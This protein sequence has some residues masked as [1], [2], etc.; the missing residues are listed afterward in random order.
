MS[1]FKSLCIGACATLVV[2]FFVFCVGTTFKACIG[3]RAK[4]KQELGKRL[5]VIDGGEW[6]DVRT[7]TVT[8]VRIHDSMEKNWNDVPFFSRIV[9]CNN[10]LSFQRQRYLHGGIFHT[11]GLP[12]VSDRLQLTLG[13][14]AFFWYAHGYEINDAEE[15]IDI[16]FLSADDR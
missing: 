11:D 15:I 3:L 8:V 7:D 1:R 9:E 10:G 4:Q 12:S 13:K 6:V 5:T 2:L 16:T 14:R